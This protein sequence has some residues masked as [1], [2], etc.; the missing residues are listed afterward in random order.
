MT[1]D[2]WFAILISEE[3]IGDR[4]MND[5]QEYLQPLMRGI[6]LQFLREKNT[7]IFNRRDE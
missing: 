2:A 1:T 5:H 6:V 7:P 4:G 3:W